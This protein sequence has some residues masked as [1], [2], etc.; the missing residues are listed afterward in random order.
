M[1][2]PP[3]RRVHGEP[4]VGYL[5]PPPSPLSTPLALSPSRAA[6]GPIC[7]SSR[8]LQ[9]H[10]WPELSRQTPPKFSSSRPPPPHLWVSSHLYCTAELHR[11]PVT[12]PDGRSAVPAIAVGHVRQDGALLD[13]VLP[14][15]RATNGWKRLSALVTPVGRTSPGA[16][17]SPGNRRREPLVPTARARREVED[18]LLLGPARQ[19]PSG[20][21]RPFKWKRLRPDPPPLHEGAVRVGASDV[22]SVVPCGWAG[23]RSICRLVRM[24][25]LKPYFLFLFHVNFKNP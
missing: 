6:P 22:A 4:R 2:W 10:P 17:C 23:P 16:L 14:G 9:P 18:G 1:P 25:R 19:R 8:A 11:T 5:R 13:Q 12:P 21:A 20:R 24:I 15:M 3:V 7:P